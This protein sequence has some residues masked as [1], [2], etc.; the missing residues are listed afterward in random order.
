MRTLTRYILLAALAAAGSSC[1]DVVRDGRSPV[2]LVI[3]LLGGTN[4]SGEDSSFAQSDVL[5]DEGSIFNDVGTVTLRIVPKDIGSTGNV[6]P[7]TNNEVTINRYRVV[8]RR[9]DGRNVQGRDVPY[10]FDGAVTG[11]VP[12]TGTLALGFVLVRHVAKR[13]PPLAQLS[14][15]TVVLT[16]IADV[17]FYGRDRVGNDINVTGSIQVDFANFADSDD[18]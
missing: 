2:F 7:S 14:T 10:S 8:Y 4:S 15:S 13:E 11:T 9:A 6:A 16:T 5:T 1:G 17:T 12:A 18:N 3:D